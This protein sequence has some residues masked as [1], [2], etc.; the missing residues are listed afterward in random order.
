[1]KEN[2][3][4]Y[5]RRASGLSV[6]RV[7]AGATTM[8]VGLSLLFPYAAFAEEVP[9][10]ARIT[11]VRSLDGVRTIDTTTHFTATGIEESSLRYASTIYNKVDDD[12]NILLT[13]SKWATLANGWGTDANNPYA[14]QYLLYFSNDEF[15]KQ[16][17]RI[18]VDDISMVKRDDGALWMLEINNKNLSSGLIGV[19]T[20]HNVKITLKD[21]KTL[22]SMGMAD[23]EITFGSVWMKGNGTIA[24]ESI[25]NGYILQNNP[26]IKNEMETGFTAGQMTQRVAFDIENMALKSVHTFK[27]NENFMQSDYGW[28]LYIKEQIPTELLKYIDR[29]EIYVY[30]SDTDGVKYDAREAFKINV[31]DNGLVDTS[32]V[33][34]LSIIGN[35]TKTQ[36]GEARKNLDEVFWG[37]LGQS[38]NYT[39]SY[40]LKDGVSV[41]DFAKAMN[42]YIKQKNSRILFEH[43][44]VADYLNE[45]NQNIVHKPDGGAEPKQLNNS[46]S[47]A[48]L[49]TNDTDQDGLFDFVEWQIGTDAAQ[50]DTDG[51]GVPDGKEFL[52]DNTNPSD[53]SDYLVSK[54]TTTTTDFDTTKK[55]TIVGTVPKPL[56][57]DPSDPTRM[58][59]VTSADAGNVIVKLQK[60]DEAAGTYTKDVYAET[61]IPFDDLANGEFSMDV[62]ANLIKDG[63]KVVLVAYSPNGK[64]PVIGDAFAYTKQ[65]D[66]EKYTPVGQPVSVEKDQEPNAE[67]GIQNKD[68]MPTGTTY[69]WKTKV[70][71]STEGE[72]TGTVVVTYPD[73]TKDEVEVKVNVTDSRPDNEKY[74]PVGQPVSVEKDQE[75][76]A[77]DGIQNKDD[78]PTGTT[79]SWK[80]KVDTSNAG[81]TTGTVVV[82]YPDKT[83]DEV[84]VKVTVTDKAPVMTDTERYTAVGGTVDKPYGEV[85]TA[86]EILA[87]VTTDAPDDKVLSKE[88]TSAIP[89]TGTNQAVNVTVTYADKTTDT[90]AVIVNYGAASDKYEPTGQPITVDKGSQPNAGDGI[91]NQ[92]ELPGG[93]T[94]A[95]E[96][97]VDTSTPGTTTGTIVVTYPDNTTDTVTVDITVN[98]TAPTITDT[99]QYTAVGG[100]V[101]KAYG[102]TATVDEILAAVTTDAPDDRVMSKDVVSAIPTEG[103]NQAVNVTVTYADGTTD[104]VSVTVNYGNASDTY[105]PIGQPITVDKGSQ[106]NAADGVANKDELPGGTTYTWETPV[107]TNTPG[108]TTG[109]V[110]VTYPD[111][112]TDRITVDVTVNDNRTDAEKYNP[113]GQPISVEKDKEAIAEAGIQNKDELPEGTVY[114]WKNPVDTSVV[115]DKNGI[116]VVTYPDKTT[117]EVNVMITVTDSRSDADKYEPEPQPIIVDKDKVP[118]PEDGIK[119]KDELP[120]DTKYTWEK[121]VDTSKPGDTTGTII[122]TYPDGTTDKVTVDITVKKDMTDADKYEPNT[123]PEIIKPGEKPDLTDNIT[124][125]KDLPDGTI[126]KD[127]TPDGAIDL[128]K[129]GDYTGT[130]EV[131]YPDGSKDTAT[132]KITVREPEKKPETKAPVQSGNN[133]SG[134]STTGKPASN[135]GIVK[136]GDHM[137]VAAGMIAMFGSVLALAG[138][139][140]A[141]IK[142]KR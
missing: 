65:D 43:W 20:N 38:R 94:Y 59:A 75:P 98:D 118:D 84:E 47:N 41:A 60:Y 5:N 19:V 50:V 110:I 90:V 74:T 80:T 67:D 111:N 29:D 45:S 104:T 132:V 91:A 51:D 92:G 115:G 26:N 77:E 21:G 32:T 10:E 23:K 101:D 57:A 113:M 88:V 30:S 73:K 76:N 11:M 8:L 58:L 133:N 86:D 44:L 18:T 93:T 22:E 103:T 4:R 99:E 35:D 125:I 112:S 7:T 66:N 87:V 69:S 33:P 79:Y 117:D 64:N 105:E 25:S 39:I 62:G 129:P 37:T 14:G 54:P 139:A 126:I 109:T 6:R 27:P 42:E 85:A 78:M 15:Y 83:K 131:L 53:A 36:L 106:P 63:D 12:G 120:D 49:D 135:K 3:N 142:K 24:K 68:D 130:V 89:A 124:N 123:E 9:P 48:Y 119:N 70:D 61:M 2:Q 71:T 56:L 72:T 107:D 137:N 81:E 1:M 134:N 52:D 122:V 16:I 17:D 128:N 138:A 100:T 127:V 13:L 114:T 31:D 96:T 136:T 28:V 40:K 46:Y 141:G 34:E 95:W 102:D 55:T 97:P 121:P 140:F 108:T 82:S 116:I